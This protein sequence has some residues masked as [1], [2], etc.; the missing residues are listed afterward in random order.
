MSFRRW[1]PLI[2]LL[3]LV[4]PA[5]LVYAKPLSQPPV[6]H[7]IEGREACLSCHESGLGGA[8]QIPQDHEG[9]PNQTCTGCHSPGAEE[10]ST[11]ARAVPTPLV[12]PHR[13]E[14]N[15][16][17]DC[18]RSLAGEDAEIAADWEASL[19]SRR[20]VTCA[21][22]HGGDPGA[23]D[24]AASMSPEA[25]YIG[26]PKKE[27]IPALCSSCHAN[28]QLMRQYNLPTDQWAKFGESIHGQ[29]L[30]E[31][32]T[33]VATCFD[34]HGGHRTNPA[35][36]PSSAV[37]PA[38]IPAMCAECHSDA[39]YMRPYDQPTDQHELYAESVHGVAL[40]Q[41]QDLRAPNCAT[42]HGKHGAAPPGFT[43]VANVCG[44]CHSAT[45]DYYAQGEHALPSSGA[46]G[47]PKC[48]TCHGPHDIAWTSEEL[49]LGEQAGSCTSCHQD[50]TE[51]AQVASQMYEAL[52]GAAQSL[53]EAERALDEA[54][55]SGLIVAPE[56]AKLHEAT[57]SLVEARAVQHDIKLASLEEL[58][59]EV[60]SVSG[61]V[62]TD[63]EK[64]MRDAVIRRWAMV[65]AV[66]GVGLTILALYLIKR[67]L[68]REWL[69]K[70]SQ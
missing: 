57:T 36:E 39:E 69:S 49:F 19:H 18:H 64:A 46:I 5:T 33:R 52:A 41:E 35:N 59:D 43:E 37:Y 25:G 62:K 32:D 51:Q 31:G 8:A 68:D 67:E 13:G 23:T 63:A 38:N 66:A 16:C 4:I 65:I 28:A 61:E 6:P 45:Q 20:G 53:G 21:H 60:Y 3:L 2:V 58:T 56:E 14:T 10:E 24:M 70:G 9:R 1:I 40:L 42:C 29:R 44:T 50:G 54:A 22:C 11:P 17:F 47:N 27:D 26:V 48:V 7:A 15:T 34:C 30:E 55:G 12:F